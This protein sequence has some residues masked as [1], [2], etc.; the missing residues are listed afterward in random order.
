MTSTARAFL[1]GWNP[2]QFKA[3]QW[4]ELDDLVREGGGD[5][6]WN[7]ASG[8]PRVNDW[9]FATKLGQQGRGIFAR[10]RITSIKK[11]PTKPGKKSEWHVE[12]HWD[13][14]LDPREPRN[15]LAFPKPAQKPP[16]KWDAESNGTEVKNFPVAELHGLWTQ[17]YARHRQPGVVDGP[18]HDVLVLIRRDKFE[19]NLAALKN[20]ARVGETVAFAQWNANS[21]ELEVLKHGGSLWMIT[22]RPGGRVWL[23]AHYP[24]PSLKIATTGDR[25]LIR[26]KPAPNELAMQDITDLVG[27]LRFTNR[28]PI[29]MEP[30]KV[31][32]SAQT[33]GILEHESAQLL[34]DAVA[35]GHQT[36]LAEHSILLRPDLRVLLQ[37]PQD[38][39]MP[40]A[41]QIG[42]YVK[43]LVEPAPSPGLGPTSAPGLG[44]SKKPPKGKKL[45]LPDAVKVQGSLRGAPST[46]TPVGSGVGHVDVGLKLAGGNGA[47]TVTL[48]AGTMMTSKREDVQHGV[49][50]QAVV[51]G[52]PANT[53][54]H[55]ILRMYCANKTRS[56]AGEDAEFDLGPVASDPVLDH[57]FRLLEPKEIPEDMVELV[58]QAVW[59]ITDGNG[60]T[61][62]TTSKLS[63]LPTRRRVSA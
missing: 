3:D 55:W 63:A 1:F 13:E 11:K 51:F 5:D 49:L 62:E 15:L 39:T 37:V 12:M 17:H 42:A 8:Q 28:K 58:Q 16:Q 10:G 52:V 46:G 25:F 33:V 50:V 53:T 18:P 36:V 32:H 4:T 23:V 29:A 45:A 48:P 54:T 60:L 31:A 43:A 21:P 35:G 2:K 27:D 30:T 57:L 22:V 19:A 38:L 47:T 44:P 24:K 56:P 6:A 20:E 61:P 14:L 7:S 59:E 26:S 9:A 40:E 41:E 34:R